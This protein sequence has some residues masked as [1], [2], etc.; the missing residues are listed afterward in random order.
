MSRVVFEGAHGPL[1][2]GIHLGSPKILVKTFSVELIIIARKTINATEEKQMGAQQ[3]DSLKGFS[4]AVFVLVCLIG[5]SIE[6]SAG[7]NGLI[8]P[9]VS[10]DWTLSKITFS[11]RTEAWAAG[12][13]VSNGTGVL[14]RYAD[15]TWSV[16]SPPSV[17]SWWRLSDVHFPTG[18]E[19][20]AVGA[21]MAGGKGV[22]FHFLDGAWNGV[23]T[24]PV[25]PDWSLSEVHF[26]SQGLGWSV[27]TDAT[28]KRG[29]ILQILEGTVTSLSPPTVSQDWGLRGVF[30]PSVD[31]GWAVGEDRANGRG[32]ILH[33]ADGLWQGVTP[34][35][36][37]SNWRLHAVHFPSVAEGWAVG[38]DEENGRGVLLRYADGLWENVTPPY[39]SEDWELHD[40]HLTPF[41]E[42]WAVG[43]DYTNG[44]GVLLRFSG[45]TWAWVSPPEISTEWGLLG[46]DLVSLYQGFAVGWDGVNRAGVLVQYLVPPPKMVVTPNVIN[47]GIVALGSFSQQEAVV[48]NEGFSDLILLE[49]GDEIAPPFSRVGGECLSG[50]V[51]SPG[52]ECA[53]ALQFAPT[54]VGSFA[55]EIV[56]SS[57]DP[58]HIEFVIP[59]K[60][61]AGPDLEGQWKKF[62]QACKTRRGEIRCRIKAVL[63]VRNIG[64]LKASPNV[65]RFYLSKDAYLDEEDLFIGRASIGRL[66]PAEHKHIKIKYKLGSGETP[67][68]EYLL[69]AVDADDDVVEADETN[70]ISLFGPI[71]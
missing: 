60:G 46:L 34:P 53:I 23:T 57:S 28:A 68:G 11:S 13:D 10:S 18:T 52:G 4:I 20:W 15:G 63:E 67:T 58:D 30:F 14:L 45:G 36:V 19:G 26:P 44:K 47:F 51:I 69:A 49:V 25:S 70:N 41:G 61:G 2:E 55:S 27:G 48:R 33:Y 38:R 39:V 24:P 37:S 64:N 6:A 22:L 3:T 56:L 43:V 35:A 12:E 31:E 42:G 9:A 1:V 16:F 62:V 7:W 29:V 5:S 21:D 40:I 32:V 17:S 65:V 54:S 50:T 66:K 71:P 8:P 59:M